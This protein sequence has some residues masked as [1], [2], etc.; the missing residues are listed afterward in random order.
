MTPT[1]NELNA[2]VA[3]L[4][5]FMAGLNEGQVATWPELNACVPGKMLNG[6]HYYLLNAARKR[7]MNDC[8][9]VFDSVRGVGIKRCDDLLKVSGCGAQTKKI[10]RAIRR[11]IQRLEAVDHF[12]QLPKEMREQH[13]I[14]QTVFK[15]QEHLMK[16]AQVRKIEERVKV[17]QTPLTPQI[18][19]SLFQ[20]KSR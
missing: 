14:R 2:D 10:R 20:T 6:R 1:T 9:A 11:G 19:L 18:S 12:E 3:A 16:R 5:E 4:V 8:N 7:L 13:Q 15:M 17:V